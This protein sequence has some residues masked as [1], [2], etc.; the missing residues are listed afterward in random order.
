[1]NTVDST[2]FLLEDLDQFEEEYEI[3]LYTKSSSKK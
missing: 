2:V 1:M 3:P